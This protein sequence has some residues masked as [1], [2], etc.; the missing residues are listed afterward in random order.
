MY[1]VEDVLVHTTHIT[2]I[3]T[4]CFRQHAQPLW[5]L[6]NEK[7]L[8]GSTFRPEVSAVVIVEV[9]GRQSSAVCRAEGM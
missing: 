5:S 3:F 2:T 9:Q 8:Q 6:T 7:S 1:G 4:F